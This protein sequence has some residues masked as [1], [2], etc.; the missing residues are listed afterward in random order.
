MP[1][2]YKSHPPVPKT[3]TTKKYKSKLVADV[4]FHK[5]TNYSALLYYETY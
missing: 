5:R 4:M 3:K 2:E 1:I